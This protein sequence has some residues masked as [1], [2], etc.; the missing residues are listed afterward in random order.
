MPKTRF[1]SPA[2][3]PRAE[4]SRVGD[5]V[6]WLGQLGCWRVGREVGEGIT[7]N[8]SAQS[9]HDTAPGEKE[10]RPPPARALAE[11]GGSICFTSC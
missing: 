2:L 8:L 10:R 5:L 3:W 11:D 4:K 7:P 6:A 1:T 9:R